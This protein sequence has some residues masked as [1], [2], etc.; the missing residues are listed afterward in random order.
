MNEVEKFIRRRFSSDNN[1]L[2]GNCFWF[3][4][5]LKNRFPGG[6]I[7]YMPI[8]GHFIYKYKNV[9]YDWRGIIVPDERVIQ[10]STI[11]RTDPDWYNRLVDN[12]LK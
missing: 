4:I 3:S 1:W 8:A 9:F 10:L 6:R 11:K 5:I 2:T 7:Y 12:C